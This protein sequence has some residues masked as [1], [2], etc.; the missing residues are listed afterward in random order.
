MTD[1][2]LG[3]RITSLGKLRMKD[4]WRL[5]LLHS[6]AKH[7]LYWITRGQGRATIRGVTR[8]YGPNTAMFLPAGTQMAI[9]LPAQLQGIEFALPADNDLGLPRTPFQRRIATIEGQASLTG[10]LE[11]AERELGAQAPAMHRALMGYGL[12]I[13]AWITRE[14]STDQGMA[15]RERSHRLVEEFADAV[16]KRFRSGAGV[17]DYAQAL[18][19][20][21]THLSR[22]CRDAAGRPALALL[23]ERIMHEARRLLRDTDMP[24]REIAQTLGFSSAAYFTRAF[25]Q[26]TGKAPI[27]YRGLG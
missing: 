17:A 12:L 19:V 1:S 13:S 9:E 10:H 24:A 11:R 7:R 26:A 14:T 5:E 25:Q 4:A 23:N 21:P 27:A 20:T 3:F 16:E 8:G 2:D 18:Q 15:L 6:E 22:V